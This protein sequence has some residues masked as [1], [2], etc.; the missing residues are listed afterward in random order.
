M[1]KRPV[2]QSSEIAWER[3][4]PL[5]LAVGQR[6]IRVFVSSSFQDMKQEREEL[7]KRVFP[8]LKKIC[9]QRG[10]AFSAVDLRWGITEE[11]ASQGRVLPICFR[12]IDACRPFFIGILGDRYGYVPE[13]IPDELLSREPW[14]ENC[15]DRSLT[16]LEILHG[17]LNDPESADHAY[18]YFRDPYYFKSRQPDFEYDNPEKLADL[19]NR[20][21]ATGVEVREDYSNPTE[22]GELVYDDFVKL[23]D[24]LFPE[25]SELD[26][27]DRDALDHELFAFSRYKVYIPRK[28]YFERLDEHAKSASQPLVVIGESGSGKSALLANWVSNYRSANP[29]NLYITHFIGATPYS[30]DWAAMVR[31]I[32]G[33]F[34]RRYGIGGDIPSEPQKL[35]SEFANWLHM[36]SATAGKR[37]E[38]VVLILD[39]LNQLEDRDSAPDLVWLPP[40]IPENIRMY[41]STLPGRPLDNLEKR[42]WPK[43]EVLPLQNSER[44]A[45]IGKY[46]GQYSK[47]L[48]KA[49][50]ERI[51]SPEQTRNP[52]YLRSFLEELRIFGI[53]ENLDRAIEHYLSSQTIPE[54]FERI[55][56]RIERDHELEWPGLVEDA[57]TSIWASRRG[58][59]EEELMELLG[60]A[61]HPMPRSRWAEFHSAV[62]M[63][64]VHRSGFVNFAH[65]YMRQAV[66]N[67]YLTNEQ[68]QTDA[69]LKL[70]N[71][72]EKAPLSERSV[73][74]LPW[75]LAEGKS[76]QMLFELLGDLEFLKKAWGKDEFEVKRLWAKVEAESELKLVDVY[77]DVLRAPQ[78]VADPMI[79]MSVARLLDDTGHL[80]EALALSQFL[81]EQFNS[82]GD[83]SSLQRALGELGIALY[84]RG[85]L[86]GAMKLY[87]ER[88]RICRELGEAVELGRILCNQATIVI[89]RGDFDAA[90]KLLKEAERICRELDDHTGLAACLCNQGHVLTSCGD[91]DGAMNLLKEAERVCREHGDPKWLGTSLGMQANILVPRG[92]LDG[93]MELLKE[94]ER[95]CR[96]LGETKWLATILGMQAD[97]LIPRGDLDG[98]MKLLKEGERI[99]RE[100]G[101]SDWLFASLCTQATVLINSGDLDGAMKLLKE[102]ERVSREL[103]NP[104]GLQISLSNQAMVFKDREEYDK[105]IALLDEAERVCK[106]HGIP[107]GLTNCLIIRAEVLAAMG[108]REEARGFAQEAFEFPAKHGLTA[109]A[110]KAKALLDSLR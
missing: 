63:F 4:T 78:G 87:K 81:V 19:K 28:E 91:L 5:G 106:E 86:N 16:E 105:A 109:L 98:A 42:E 56:K 74:E 102:S 62:E 37:N 75:Q 9:G 94:V 92:D 46:L 97:T 73:D 34:K 104:D 23:I 83:P 11:Q 96:E 36:A 55:L 88:E 31:R 40:V 21:R 60:T 52:L 26:P 30:A 69:H 89:I 67:R 50:E 90:M 82:I 57:M 22:L 61:G 32:M 15:R 33:E 27:L 65:D 1:S 49:R 45:L 20:I 71:L 66:Q 43:L 41:L 7:V 53:H 51:T 76:W 107:E 93:A 101:D 85:D 79:L 110:N 59:S 25:G 13:N 17:Y 47:A 84:F 35:R 54:L 2:V 24:E 80:D 70:V 29:G 12:E 77:A 95:M 100:L 103:D 38:K 108:R 72:F 68:K 3:R 6:M 58:L 64:F 14:L 39:A 99:C 44:T 10:V 18:F 48:D 8:K